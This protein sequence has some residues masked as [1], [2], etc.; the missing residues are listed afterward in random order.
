MSTDNGIRTEKLNIGYRSDLIKDICL[1]VKPGRIV[2]LIGPNGCGKTTLLK[3]LTGE[4]KERGGVVYIDGDDRSVLKA[5]EKAKRLSIVMTYRIKAELITCREVV[6]TGRYPYTGSLGILSDDDRRKVM[7]AMGWTDTAE[8]EN[9]P[10]QNIS[11]GQ[12]QRVLLA[13]AICQEPHI[14]ILDEPTSFLDIRHKLDILH[15]MI[16]FAK[17]N[18][19]AVLMSLHELEIARNISDTVVALGEGRVLKTGSPSEVFT[20]EFIRKLYHIENTDT[21]LLGNM[22]WIEGS[23]LPPVLEKRGRAKALMIQGTMSNAGKSLIAAGLCRILADAG[24][25]TV[26]FKSQ[27]M[28]L[29]SY[30]T[31]EGLEMGRAQVVQAEC[32]RVEPSVLMNPILLK[33][34]GDT[35]SQV[36]LNGRAVGNMTA[37]EYL[38]RRKEY[39]KDILEAYDRLSKTADII[40]IEGAGS[41]VEMNLKKDDFVNMGL[42]GMTD[43]SVLL[44]GDI[45]RGGIFAQL[46]GT[47]DLL[48]ADERARVAGLI[49]N[50][51]R[52]DRGLFD[53]GIRILEDRG[54]IKVVGV[55]PYMDIDIDD[56]DSLS[57][58]LDRSKAGDFD[59][60]VIR[61]KHISNFTDFAVF[62]QMDG[63]SVRYVSQERE[64][65]D[66]DVIIIPGT[67]NTMADL[68]LI[69]E[70][71]LADAVIS[72]AHAG[73]CIFGICGGY[74]MLGRRVEDPYGAEE[75]GEQEGLGLLPVDTVLEK[76]KTRINTVR[77]ITGA[78]GIL[79]GIEH[80]EAEGYEIHM[81]KTTPYE[82]LMEFTSGQSGYCRDNI[83]GTYLHGFFDRK[84]VAVPVISKI[85]ATRGKRAGFDKV[86]D[87]RVFRERQ[88]DLLA[89]VLRESLDMEYIFGIIGE[90]YDA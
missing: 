7:E 69:R 10:F 46:L 36:I 49:V 41:P 34:T 65:G 72:K 60:A 58:R 48:E 75:G 23:S 24:L 22:P 64:L 86:E 29:N 39:V 66:P 71:R 84:D 43:A 59:I 18:G 5:S 42:A 20:E 11:D 82:E 31:K 85:A 13:R 19:V 17:E 2:T 68:K 15:K 4:L 16:S 83:Y 79:K 88:Y 51:F 8:L 87:Y 57:E 74:Q 73:T 27:N 12:K 62:G 52:G 61:L 35:G 44:V 67:K 3:T 76:D 21:G 63:V 1:E 38:K 89:D 80:T 6:E 54:G 45:D 9:I 26:P 47:L 53:E 28:A 50:K 78:S 14:L 81:G 40:V 32:A 37:G 55:V 33:P 30:I 77:M 56:E 70:N 90:K 25:R